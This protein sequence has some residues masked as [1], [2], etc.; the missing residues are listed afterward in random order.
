MIGKHWSAL[1]EGIMREDG[2]GAVEV[3]F[4]RALAAAGAVA[5]QRDIASGQSDLSSGAPEL[6]G[7]KDDPNFASLT[8]IHPDDRAWLARAILAASKGEAPYDFEFRLLRPDGEVE[9][10]RDRGQLQRDEQGRP[11]RLAGV[12]QRV[13]EWKRT[14]V[15]FNATFEQAAVGMAHLSP[16]GHFLKVNESLCRLLRRTRQELLTTTIQEVTHP[17]HR[18]TDQDQRAL[19]LQGRTPTAPMSGAS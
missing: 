5:W 9:W 8:L 18:D 7:L 11:L 3:R 10:V 1:V 17:D 13:T 2:P 4:E 16:D 6:L 12:A 15:A 19:L 14:E